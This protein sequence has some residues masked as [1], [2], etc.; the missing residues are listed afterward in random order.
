MDEASENL[1]PEPQLSDHELW[2]ALKVLDD[3]LYLLCRAREPIP[4]E[5]L[6]LRKVLRD[7]QRQR[8]DI[9]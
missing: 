5:R 9:A 3:E 7:A 2:R 6:R 8:A 1:P 4:I